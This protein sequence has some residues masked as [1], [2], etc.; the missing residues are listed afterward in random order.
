MRSRLRE[1]STPDEVLDATLG[2]LTIGLVPVMD[3]VHEGHLA[4]IQ[5]SVAENDATVIALISP[6]GHAP[7]LGDSGRMALSDIGA[8]IVYRSD[9]SDADSREVSTEIH[10]RGVTD[11]YEGEVRPGRINRVVTLMV[12]LINQVQP[13]RAYVGEKHLQYVAALT[14][15][16]ADLSLAGEIVPCPVLRDPDGLPLSSYNAG[17]AE[18]DREIARTIPEA[19]F[20]MQHLVTNGETDSATV[21]A[22]GRTMIATQPTIQIDY[23]EIVDLT[24]FDPVSTVEAG[25]HIIVGCVIDGVRILDTIHLEPGGA[26]FIA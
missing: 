8:A 23:L 19:L 20:T 1:V 24:T 22:A 6:D 25:N 10:V 3:D 4:L 21:L 14:R 16:H 9:A 13:T 7:R 5:R 26:G 15:A 12:M 2:S 17:L 11:R 18:T